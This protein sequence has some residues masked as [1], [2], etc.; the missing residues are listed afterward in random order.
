MKE[1]ALDAARFQIRHR[2]DTMRLKAKNVEEGSQDLE[3][4]SACA[5]FTYSKM[6]DTQT[7]IPTLRSSCG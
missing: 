1:Q 6:E 2:E 7:T 5:I 3:T 4:F